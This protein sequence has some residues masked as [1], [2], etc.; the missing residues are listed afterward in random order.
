M[1]HSRNTLLHETRGNR[2]KVH[3]CNEGRFLDL[4]IVVDRYSVLRKHLDTK[5][6]LLFSPQ[7]NKVGKQ[8]SCPFQPVRP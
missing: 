1:Y 5:W 4:V 7:L 2:A 8:K 3:N 6:S